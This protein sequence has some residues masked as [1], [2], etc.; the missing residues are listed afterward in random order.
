MNRRTLLAA[1]ALALTVSAPAFADAGAVHAGTYGDTS[2]YGKSMKTRAEVRA[3][4]VQAQ[5][6]GMLANGRKST[7]N[8][9][10]LDM[11]PRPHRATP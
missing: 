8:V 3:E 1:L 6:D 5:Q 10:G 4:L 7:S 2:W 11:M 9:P